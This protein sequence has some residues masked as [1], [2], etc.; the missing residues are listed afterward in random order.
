MQ[1]T[2][3]KKKFI[4]LRSRIELAN[5]DSRLEI[6]VNAKGKSQVELFFVFDC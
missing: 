3:K 5:E 4:S 1:I 2:S 6:N